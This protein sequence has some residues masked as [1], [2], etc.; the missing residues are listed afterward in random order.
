MEN[1]IIN[2][3][4]KKKYDNKK[5]YQKF[6]EKHQNELKESITCDICG[7]SYK[8]FNKSIH[9]KTKK[10]LKKLENEGYEKAMLL[11]CL[12]K[13]LTDLYDKEEL[14]KKTLSNEL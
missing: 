7:G 6:K 1:V 4:G 11:K 9:I 10:H 2:S 8:Y 13:K 14:E 12:L 3:E 5:Y